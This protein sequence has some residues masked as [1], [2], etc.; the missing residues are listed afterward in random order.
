MRLYRMKGR[1]SF[2]E[3]ENITEEIVDEG[4]T[5]TNSVPSIFVKAY[6]PLLA[7][8]GKSR[9]LT[10]NISKEFD[11]DSDDSPKQMTFSKRIVSAKTPKVSR[12]EKFHS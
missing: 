8:K 6:N 5:A 3:E 10:L 12:I 1:K 9:L 2:P 11:L 7:N 4:L